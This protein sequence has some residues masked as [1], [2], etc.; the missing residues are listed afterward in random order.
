MK[1][2][3]T[4]LDVVFVTI[5]VDYAD[6]SMDTT[7]RCVNIKLYWVKGVILLLLLALFTMIPSL[8]CVNDC[9]RVS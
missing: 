7:E 5:Q 9:V 6:V 1:L 4:A 3:V 8:L 2:V